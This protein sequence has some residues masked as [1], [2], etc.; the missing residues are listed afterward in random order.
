M[1][2]GV[3]LSGS[4]AGTVIKGEGPTYSLLGTAVGTTIGFKGGS[5]YI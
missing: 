3:G 5:D 1:T 4:Y 2:Q